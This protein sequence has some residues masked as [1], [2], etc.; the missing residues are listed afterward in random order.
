MSLDKA[1]KYI[2]K[3]KNYE[4]ISLLNNKNINIVYYLAKKNYLQKGGSQHLSLEELDKTE[5]MHLS[6]HGQIMGYRELVVPDGIYLVIPLCCGFSNIEGLFNYD[7]YSKGDQQ[8]KNIVNNTEDLMKIGIQNYFLLKPRDTYCDV[9]ISITLDINITEGILTTEQKIAGYNIFEKPKE[10]IEEFIEGK[11]LRN[12]VV[13]KEDLDTFYLLVRNNSYK[14]DNS[15]IND[16]YINVLDN[17]S[18]YLFVLNGK[19]EVLFINFIYD[20]ACEMLK[21]QYLDFFKTDF[22]Q[23]TENKELYITVKDK[24][25]IIIN[26]PDKYKFINYIREL[27]QEYGQYFGSL[28]YLHLDYNVRECATKIVNNVFK[29]KQYALDFIKK[30]KPEHITLMENENYKHLSKW[31][32]HGFH[33]NSGNNSYL[34]DSNFDDG[35]RNFINLIKEIYIALSEINIMSQVEKD[36]I[37][38]MYANKTEFVTL[39]LGDLI[40]FIRTNK[41]HNLFI[42]NNSC[43][44]FTQETQACQANKCLS[45]ISKKLGI[46]EKLKMDKS[47]NNENLEDLCKALSYIKTINPTYFEPGKTP[48]YDTNFNQIKNHVWSK[49]KS[50]INENDINNFINVFLNF[51]HEKFLKLYDALQIQPWQ[52]HNLKIALIIVNRFITIFYNQTPVEKHKNEILKIMGELE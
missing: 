30:I 22:V 6:F 1:I 43:Q 24:V 4:L 2:F 45:N 5:V 52:N 18:Q 34:H 42:F 29:D 31:A 33:L 46:S 15:K 48:N 17:M 32:A 38:S 26:E 7:F 44:P 21:N 39:Y 14:F 36:F 10:F 40:N 41:Q 37:N 25:N 47:F 20:Q 13:T 3:S 23:E 8:L 35:L 49:Q 28:R 51:L 11:V 50:T 19:R 16:K 12:F 9:R 27:V